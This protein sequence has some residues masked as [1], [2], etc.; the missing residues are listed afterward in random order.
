[1]AWLDLASAFVIVLVAELGDKTQLAIAVMAARGKALQVFLGAAAAFLALTLLAVTLGA[2]LANLVSP[3]WTNLAAGLLFLGMAAA[4]L[5]RKD[6]DKDDPVRSAT[7]GSAF[8]AVAL[9]EFGDKSQLATS[10]LAAQGHAVL[11]GLGVLLALL[12]SAALA[13]LLGAKL[14][15]RLP[16]RTLKF[17]S[18]AAFLLAGLWLLYLGSRP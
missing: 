10:A 17:A 12:L 3:R 5:I 4:T 8:A 16:K 18:F 11:V 9:A 7:L 14:L 1:V 2:A 15:A 6:D 13:A